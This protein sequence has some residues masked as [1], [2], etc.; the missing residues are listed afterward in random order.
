MH[1]PTGTASWPAARCVVPC[2]SPSRKSLC[3][4]CSKRRMSSIRPYAST[5]AVAAFSRSAVRA[6]ATSLLLRFV[7]GRATTVAHRRKRLQGS[8]RARSAAAEIGR[9]AGRGQ[10]A[11]ERPEQETE[12]LPAVEVALRDPLV[13]DAVDE[14]QPPADGRARGGRVGA[15]APQDALGR[16]V[17]DAVDD[18]AHVGLARGALDE[19]RVAVGV[20]LDPREVRV[21]R[22]HERLRRRQVRVWLDAAADLLR[23]A[24][25]RGDEVVAL[26]R[27]VVVEQGFRDPRL[28]GDPGH[29]ELAVAVLG[30]EP[31]AELEQAAAALVVLQAGVGGLGHGLRV[32]P[33]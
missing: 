24:R 32:V 17:A 10:R 3:I 7:C 6:S 15:Q 20:L 1:T 23:P 9:R 27:E 12:H 4:A 22:A 31:L 33:A 8:V 2:T 21:E 19:P 26:A 30:E 25:E 13:A 5:Y 18:L 16:L 11:V 28:A 14:P 29:R